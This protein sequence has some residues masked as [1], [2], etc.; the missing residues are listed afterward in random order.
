[1]T[2]IVAG[3]GLLRN[4]EWQ[5]QLS[6]LKLP[7]CPEFLISLL[8]ISF[9]QVP[10]VYT[11]FVLS[12]FFCLIICS[13]QIF[14]HLLSFFC[15]F[16]KL[17]SFKTSLP[18]WGQCLLCHALLSSLPS[19]SQFP[20][21]WVCRARYSLHLSAWLHILGSC[22]GNITLLDF[23]TTCLWCFTYCLM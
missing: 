19:C 4:F 23:S 20:L 22:F 8:S 7:C 10:V 12:I 14:F 9:C 13:F 21:L 15:P 3:A 17:T 2:G 11:S 16:L 6:F 5:G 1:M 18:F